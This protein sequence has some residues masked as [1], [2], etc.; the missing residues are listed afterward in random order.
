MSTLA[1]ISSK[2]KKDGG[3]GHFLFYYSGHAGTSHFLLG[4]ERVD[5]GKI[6]KLVRRLPAKVRLMIVDSCYSGKLIRAKSGAQA[7][8][9]SRRSFV[10]WLPHQFRIRTKGF[11]LLTSSGARERSYESERI[12]SS[13][14]TSSLLAGLRGA[15]DRNKDQ[16]VS[17]SEIRQYVYQRTIAHAASHDV[18]IQRPAHQINLRGQGP[19]FLTYLKHAQARMKLHSK[20]KGHFFIYRKGELLHEFQKP[21]GRPILVALR[22]GSYQVQVRRSGWIGVLDTTF[23]KSQLKRLAS[24]HFRWQQISVKEQIKG[25]SETFSTGIGLLAHY[26]PIGNMSS[27]GFGGSLTLDARRWL[28]ISFR[29]QLALTNVQDLPHSTHEAALRLGFGYGLGLQD[30]WIWG[31]AFLEPR[32]TWRVLTSDVFQNAGIAVGGSIHFDYYLN[33]N[34]AMRLLASGGVHW[35]LFDQDTIGAP[36]LDVAIGL[37]LRL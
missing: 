20:L 4:K 17:L 21:E 35:V 18:G 9:A 11:A 14:F 7:K 37:L 28:N 6:A 1:N 5:F 2:L 8:G 24:N 34:W 13:F 33:P 19:L 26:L 22:A 23:P 15:A 3:K 10:R 29:Y 30:F 32:M 31:G 27:H 16:R 36:F 25:G 12:R